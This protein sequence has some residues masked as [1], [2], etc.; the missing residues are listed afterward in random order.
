M[1][2]YDIV[3]TNNNILGYFEDKVY[4]PYSKEEKDNLLN[5]I[6]KDV[7]KKDY[8]RKLSSLIIG[9]TM[10][11]AAITLA[12]LMIFNVITLGNSQWFNFTFI[13]AGLILLWLVFYFLFGLIFYRKLIINFSF[14]SS[15]LNN[16]NSCVTFASSNYYKFVNNYFKY[17][18]NTLLYE[19]SDNKK[20]KLV[21]FGLKK[22]V[23]YSSFI[24]NGNASTNIAYYY[25]TVK[26]K[27]F[28]FLPGFVIIV[29]GKNSDVI[30]NNEFIAKK[31]E[32]TYHLYKNDMLITSFVDE[33]DFNINFF[34]FKYDQIV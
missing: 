25:L 6:K 34:H 4:K 8:S 20:R 14:K 9:L 7:I 5:N 26:S 2:K 31:N 13:C 29:D 27:K 22:P 24:F 23:G 19:N 17:V 1:N 21:L 15:K 3:Y 12:I 11:I 10:L 32:K 33:K 18:K 30:A 16:P 28:L